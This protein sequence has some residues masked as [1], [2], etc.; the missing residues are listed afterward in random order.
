MPPLAAN[1]NW[2]CNGD[3]Y[4]RADFFIDWKLGVWCFDRHHKPKGY[5]VRECP[6]ILT[7]LDV[8][9]QPLVIGQSYPR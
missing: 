9:Q 3:T 4:E 1:G 2:N 8:K 7:A 6:G 5:R